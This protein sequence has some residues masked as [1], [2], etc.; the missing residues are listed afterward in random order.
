MLDMN[1]V[2]INVVRVPFLEKKHCQKAVNPL[3]LSQMNS[4]TGA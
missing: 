1:L 4:N 2:K 3:Q